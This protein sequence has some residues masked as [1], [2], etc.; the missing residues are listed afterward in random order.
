V[1]TSLLVARRELVS[2]LLSP[3]GYI[4]VAV[5]LLA[6]GLLFN[7]FAMQGEKRSFDVLQAF[8]YFSSGTTMVAAIF[9]SMRL[10]AEEKQTGTIV[11]LET[12]PAAEHQVVIGKFLG[13]WGFLLLLTACTVYMPLLVLVNGKV[14][15]G[16]LLAGYLGLALLG[17][18]CTAIG[19]FTSSLAKSQVL[20]AVLSGALIV[21]LLL[22]WLLAKKVEGPLGDVVG[23]L[24]LFD[25]HF[26]S[27]SR[28]TVKLGSVAYY[29]SLTYAALLATTAVLSSRRWR[30]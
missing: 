20:A 19:T 8:F 23:Y 2:Y 9:I 3:L 15:W 13:A 26:R 14:T 11:L 1:T 17:A 24:D 12:S 5:I 16:H 25:R 30:G 4:I 28:G 22:A 7:A 10:F 29:L 27:F 21:A 6:D 18:A